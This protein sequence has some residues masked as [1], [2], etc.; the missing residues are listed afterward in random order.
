MK[1]EER[2]KENLLKQPVYR[3]FNCKQISSVRQE[4]GSGLPCMLKN[5]VK[6]NLKVDQVAFI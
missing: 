1:S 4:K 6:L 2:L 5:K 3:Y